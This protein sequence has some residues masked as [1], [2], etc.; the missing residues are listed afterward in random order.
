M[1]KTVVF[2]A[3]GYLPKKKEPSISQDL[4]VFLDDMEDAMA[5]SVMSTMFAEGVLV[6]PDLVKPR[7]QKNRWEDVFDGRDWGG[8]FYDIDRLV[9]M[10][11]SDRNDFSIL[12]ISSVTEKISQRKRSKHT[13]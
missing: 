10:D 1:S 4:Q 6:N 13:L 5:H 7:G 8:F 2:V 9:E 12:T 3:G 11:Y